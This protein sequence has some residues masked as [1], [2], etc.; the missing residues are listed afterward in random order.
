MKVHY[1]L[2]SFSPLY[3]ECVRNIA[4]LITRYKHLLVEFYAEVL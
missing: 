4:R 2:L 3:I 1:F